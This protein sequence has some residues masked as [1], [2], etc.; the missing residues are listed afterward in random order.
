[1]DSGTVVIV[2]S[3]IAACILLFILAGQS[4]RKKERNKLQLLVNIA[5]QHDCQISTHEICGDYVIGM[6]ESKKY[7]FFHKQMKNGVFE[8]AIDLKDIRSCNVQNSSRSI[9]NK[10]GNYQVV[11]KL[12]LRLKPISAQMDEI[13]LE[14]FN[15]N[16]SVQLFGELQSVEKWCKVINDQIKGKQ[17]I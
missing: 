9:T 10:N 7:L 1:M 2:I 5:N 8:H 13:T 14:F 4:R 11:D 12:E 3:V 17:P 15:V 6:D 16:V